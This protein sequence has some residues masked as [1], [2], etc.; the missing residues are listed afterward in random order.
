[1]QARIL[2]EEEYEITTRHP[3]NG[4]RLM[5]REDESALSTGFIDVI[6]GHH[7][8]YD[9]SGGYPDDFDISE[10]KHR[11]MI[12]II[13]VADALDAATDD[14]GGT[15]R[16]SALKTP[17]MIR[18]EI[19]AQAGKRYSPIVADALKEDIVFAEVKEILE[20]GRR[21]AYYTAYCHAW[22]GRDQE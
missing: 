17:E 18:D 15:C 22:A 2:T 10:S 5:T 1:M 14:I 3:E 19:V 6:R 8:F 13:S 20:T 12:D 11:I 9:N 7:K 16:D 21:D 4:V